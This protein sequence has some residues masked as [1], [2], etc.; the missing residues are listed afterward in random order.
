MLVRF[1][2][3]RG[4]TDVGYCSR[5]LAFHSDHPGVSS[6]K[7]S[8]SPKLC[9]FRLFACTLKLISINV[10]GANNRFELRGDTFQ[11]LT[12]RNPCE[13]LAK[14]S[15]PRGEVKQF[16][17]VRAALC[18]Q[19]LTSLERLWVHASQG[20]IYA[21]LVVRSQPTVAIRLVKGI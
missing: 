17:V 1:Q 5:L 7:G 15:A 13:L 11:G 10:Y 4:P 3:T 6:L 16:L 9:L 21:F 8:L 19:F 2:E 18:F 20:P 14:R 12:F